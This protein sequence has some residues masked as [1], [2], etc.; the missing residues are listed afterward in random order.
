[1]SI[2]LRLEVISKKERI[3]D[4]EIDAVIGKEN[5]GAIL[6][7]TERKTG[8]LLTKKLPKG[9][10]AKD[11]AMELFYLLLAYKKI[12]LS[13]TSDEEIRTVYYKINRRPR[14]SHNFDSPW[15]VFSSALNNPVA[16]VT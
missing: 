12:I 13:I 11:L 7:A 2:D 1:M 5:K 14:T 15:K 9:K 6:T 3:G 10:N 16:L 4:W 8:V